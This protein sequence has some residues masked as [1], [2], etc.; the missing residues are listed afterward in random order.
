MLLLSRPVRLRFLGLA[1]LA[2][3]GGGSSSNVDS[4]VDSDVGADAGNCFGA[5]IVSTCLTA[6]PTEPVVLAGTLDTTADP[7]CNDDKGWCVIAGTDVQLS[8]LRVTGTK[9][10]VFVATNT[11]TVDGV[12]D[13]SSRRIAGVV[14]RGPAA[15]STT[16]IPPQ[17]PSQSGGGPGG[18]FGGRG[19]NGGVGTLNSAESGLV[20]S[21]TAFRGGCGG[22][23]GAGATAGDGG[24]SG[25]AVYLIARRMIAVNGSIN[26]SGSS[27]GGAPSGGGGGGGSGGMIGL[28][29][30]T[31][32]VTGSVFAN[33]GGGGEGGANGANGTDP[34]T[35]TNPAAGGNGGAGGDGGAGS[36]G[37]T[38]TGAKGGDA[39][40]GGGGG[41]GGAGVIVMIPMQATG[42][43]ISPAPN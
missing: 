40:A 29:A 34:A 5:G 37:T 28:E 24:A 6:L 38:K 1:A 16:C 36:A 43:V 30:P 10:A 7:K 14:E 9:P 33:G 18:T 27:G 13:A 8:A 2:A 12:L 4:G 39:A 3:C 31:I 11:I 15:N 17:T 23:T 26:A 22:A 32:A 25:G 21:V 19:G 20:V 35:A 42:G 41:G